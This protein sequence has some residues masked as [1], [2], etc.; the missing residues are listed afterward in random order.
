MSGIFRWKK[1]IEGF[2]EH[3][4]I[5]IPKIKVLD[6]RPCCLGGSEHPNDSKLYQQVFP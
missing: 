3:S 1:L 2:M 5:D 4:V 6:I